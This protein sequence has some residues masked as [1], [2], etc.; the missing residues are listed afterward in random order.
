MHANTPPWETWESIVRRD[1]GGRGVASYRHNGLPLGFGDLEQAARDIAGRAGEVAIVTG[2]CIADADPPAAETDG[3]PGALFLAR[4]L[5]NLGVTVSVVGDEYS[6]RLLRRGVE[7][8]RL[9]P[10]TCDVI[11]MPSTASDGDEHDAFDGWSDAFLEQCLASG[12]TH[13]VAIERVGPSHTRTSV[14]QREGDAVADRFA[15]ETPPEQQGVAHNMRG[16]VIDR[17]TPPAH[18]LFERIAERALPV[19][20][21]GIGDG[22]N[23]IGMGRFPWSVLRRAIRVGPAAWT[24]CRIAT[25]YTIVAGVSNWGAYA[26][27]LA[28][29][30]LR[31]RR[32]L[33]ENWTAR[34]ERRMVEVLVAA[35]AVDGVSKRPTATV[36]G[37][38]LD[39]YLAVLDAL[40]RASIG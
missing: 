33:I 1:P 9:P 39:D 32:D 26:L 16:L 25:D 5:G 28:V 27:A 35:G 20:T 13:L 4:V 22:G 6:A 7:L 3:P 30:T 11:E 40:A 19:T 24:A 29:A 34:D 2:F 17:V 31:G 23:E 21:I 10:A 8:L 15:A 38:A 18:R 12:L 14:A 36:D 37:I